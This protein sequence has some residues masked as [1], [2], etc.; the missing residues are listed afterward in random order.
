MSNWLNPAYQ[1]LQDTRLR[2]PGL[3][4]EVSHA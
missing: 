3:M 4:L 1:P 2:Q